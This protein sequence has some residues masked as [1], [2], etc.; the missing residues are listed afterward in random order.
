MG[1]R[2][3]LGQCFERGPVQALCIIVNVPCSRASANYPKGLV[4]S[5]NDSAAIQI[6]RND[7]HGDWNYRIRSGKY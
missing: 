5:D 1:R 2:A 4:V 3:M 6:E 7:F